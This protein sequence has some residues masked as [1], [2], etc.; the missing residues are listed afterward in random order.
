M[1]FAKN[2]IF[3]DLRFGM[4]AFSFMQM[5]TW[6]VERKNGVFLLKS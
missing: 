1:L 3:I 4:G 6:G 5:K 2:I